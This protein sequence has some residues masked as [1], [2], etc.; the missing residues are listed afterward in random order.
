LVEDYDAFFILGFLIY[1]VEMSMRIGYAR[2]ST[3]EQ[4]FDIQMDALLKSGCEKIYQEIV[5]GSKSSRPI[6]EDMINNVRSGDIVVIYKL[7]RLGRNVNHLIKLTEHLIENKV[8]LISINDP[9]DTS[10]IQGRLVFMIFASLAEFE[11][12]LI[13]ERV[14]AGLKSARARGRVGGRPKGISNKSLEKAK[15]ASTL[16]QSKEIPIS[17]I[18]NQLRISKPTLYSYLRMMEVAVGKN[19]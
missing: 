12:S 11:R 15:I 1:D 7:D 13:Q 3:K 2:V 8:D 5:S 10:S 6:L 16:Y 19:K 14:Q 4:S 18:C 17:L 9:I